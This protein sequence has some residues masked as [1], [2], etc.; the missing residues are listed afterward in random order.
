[1]ADCIDIRRVRAQRVAQNVAELVA[2]K[3]AADKELRRVLWAS[4]ELHNQLWDLAPELRDWLAGKA[5]K[6]EGIN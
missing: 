3:E 5:A 4:G 6:P 2:R 1:M